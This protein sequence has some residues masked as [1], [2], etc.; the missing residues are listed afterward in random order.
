MKRKKWFIILAVLFLISAFPGFSE[1]IAW[2]IVGHD[3]Q[4]QTLK[5]EIVKYAN[6]GFVPMGISYYDEKLF[7]LYLYG[8]GL[9]IKGWNLEWYLDSQELAEGLNRNIANGFSPSGISDTG[10]LFFVMYIQTDGAQQT[11]NFVQT[12]MK[13][14]NYG[15]LLKPTLEESYIPVGITEMN[16]E[17]W[18]LMVKKESGETA[19]F[20]HL[21]ESSAKDE[22]INKKIVARL[23]QGM[24]PWGLKY[25]GNSVMIL[26]V[27]F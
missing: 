13:P 20:V 16:G 27:R 26:Y 7:V 21:E 1:Q 18:T 25:N 10:D 15:I 3:I 23:K 8:E 19:Q 22:A 6:R 17:F 4:A 2:Q 14:E 5:T 12:P 11:W 9:S 24:L